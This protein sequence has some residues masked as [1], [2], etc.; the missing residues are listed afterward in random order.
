MENNEKPVENI[1]TGNTTKDITPKKT[2]NKKKSLIIIAIILVI[3]FLGIFIFFKVKSN[4]N[5]SKLD[6]NN[7]EQ[8]EVKRENKYSNYQLKDNTLSNF[9]LYFL[10]LEN[11]KK[12]MVYSPLSIK[13][14]LEM[15]NSGA[16]GESKDQITDI[17]GT[18]INKKYINNKNMSFANALFVRNSYKDNIKTSYIDTLLNQYNASVSYDAFDNASTINKWIS[19]KTFNLINNAFNDEDIRDLNF[20]LANALA[21]DMDW[22]N[23]IQAPYEGYGV[24]YQHEKFYDYVLS[25]AEAGFHDLA[26]QSYDKKANAVEIAAVVNKYDI[27]N[28]L[29]E[30]NIRK[31]VSDDYSNWLKNG[32]NDEYAMCGENA[33]E[34]KLN[35][36]KYI[37]ELSA[38]YQNISSSTDFEFYVDDNVKVFAK[39]LKKYNGTT[40]QYIG[41][42]PTNETLSNYI[43]NT[44]ANSL[45]KLIDK[46]K[47]LALDSFKDGV[48]TDVHGYIPLFKFDYKLNL[49]KDLNTLGIT[50]VFDS[51]KANLSNLTTDSAYI[52]D[53]THKATIDFSNDG[54]KA[55]A[56]T[57]GGGAGAGGCGYDYLF[58][59]P[60]LKIDLTFDKPY[61]FIIRDKDTNEVWFAGTVYEPTEYDGNLN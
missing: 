3:V 24:S 42:M 51:K 36:D 45:N 39:D 47:P 19:D 33:S 52:G 1:N 13:Y 44:D 7:Q 23:K 55:G 56:F 20:V 17:L 35:L 10:Q 6:N 43:N 50:D 53:A 32:G 2:S 49:V 31:T 40:L 46:I 18:Y 16:D 34:D 12:N 27:V 41:I 28:E 59:V 57:A 22:V 38:N 5:N 9:D 4:K 48:I 61:M 29:G 21:I 8:V 37:K 25:L 58:N 26:F 30:A 11:N 15:L 54:I 60:V 14:V